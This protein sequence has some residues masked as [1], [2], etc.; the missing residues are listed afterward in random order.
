MVN[1]HPFKG[2]V[3]LYETKRNYTLKYYFNVEP[4]LYITLGTEELIELLP[5]KNPNQY[6]IRPKDHPEWCLDYS[7]KNNYYI[8][9]YPYVGNE[10]QLFNIMEAGKDLVT[11]Q[12][13]VDTSL[14]LL[15]NSDYISAGP[16]S[17]LKPRGSY[18]S[19]DTWK[20][21]IL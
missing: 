17:Y 5:G 2:T 3:R 21:E 7:A 11:I 16:S 14:Y 18:S 10:A 20:I 8:K 1:T 9:L 6:Y 12:C 19:L 4:G 15:N 13:V